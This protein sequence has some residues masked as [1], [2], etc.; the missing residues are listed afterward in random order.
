MEKRLVRAVVA[1]AL[2]VLSATFAATSESAEPVRLRVSVSGERLQGQLVAIDDSSLGLLRDGRA[3]P[4][5]IPL[6]S[7]GSIERQVR[8][9][10][11]KRGLAWGLLVGASAGAI[12]GYAAGEDCG[13]G[14]YI[15]C[16]DRPTTAGAGAA[17]FGLLGMA[18][19]VIVAPGDKWEST[20][21]ARVRIDAGPRPDGG[22]GARL[23]LRF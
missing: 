5:R 1:G 23:T 6:A 16:F 13:R 18:I 10:S 11:K 17:A 7:V 22:I 9:S 12:A 20:T 19:G 21:P 2:G 8:R 15:V 4:E 14:G 3:E